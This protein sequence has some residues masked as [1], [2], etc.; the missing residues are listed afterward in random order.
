M[1]RLAVSPPS[2]GYLTVCGLGILSV[3]VGD[4][5]RYDFV[6]RNIM[7]RG[8]A[9]QLDNRLV[10][11]YASSSSSIIYMFR[12]ETRKLPLTRRNIASFMNALN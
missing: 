10:V 2:C 1:R 7:K 12:K 9:Y 6:V 8:V 4:S 3:N 5:L 11:R